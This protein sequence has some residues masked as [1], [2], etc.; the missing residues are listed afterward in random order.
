MVVGQLVT[1]VPLHCLTASTIRIYV[2]VQTKEL[3]GLY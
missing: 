2:H 1:R 3:K